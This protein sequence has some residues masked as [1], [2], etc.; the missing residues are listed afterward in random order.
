MSTWKPRV[1]DVL[2][3][4][5]EPLISEEIL[6]AIDAT[7]IGDKAIRKKAIAA[8]SNAIQILIKDD[9]VSRHDN[10]GRGNKYWIK[11]KASI[12]EAS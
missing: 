6:E 5:P 2:A 1:L 10:V 3:N 9:K 12:S 8:I 4:A 7:L 11:Q